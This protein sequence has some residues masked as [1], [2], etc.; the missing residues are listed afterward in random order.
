MTAS[1]DRS[2]RHAAPRTAASLVATCLIA[3]GCSTTGAPSTSFTATA[4]ASQTAAPSPGAQPTPSPIVEVDGLL[5]FHAETSAGPQLFTIRPDG[6]ELRQITHIDGGAVAAE[7]APDGRRIVFQMGTEGECN[8]AFVDPD[9]ANLTILPNDDGCDAQPTLTPEGDRI[10]F[11]R[12]DP[13][14]GNDAIWGMNLDGTDRHVIGSGVGAAWNPQ[15][16]PD[17]S[18]V[19]V[20]GWNLLDG[21]DSY[22]GLYAMSIDGTD[23]RW[24]TPNWPGIFP[25]HGWSPNGES[26]VLSDRIGHEGGPANVVVV[27]ADG[28]SVTGW[29]SLTHY[30]REDQRALTPTFS[31]D[32]DWVAF[33]LREDDL[34]ALYRMRPDGSDL[35][36]LTEPSSFIPAEIDWGSAAR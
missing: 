25:E 28:S 10:V 18:L 20:S 6:Q 12:A 4:G 5:V 32:G 35:D 21:P 34:F 16:S 2:N 29:T 14:S 30:D 24:L 17:G 31:P 19:S 23:P 9:G 1:A 11:G 13:A 36:R 22:E 3:A 15:V 8:I 27:L 26:I 33:R 7:W